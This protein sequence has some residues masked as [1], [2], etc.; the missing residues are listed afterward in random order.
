MPESISPVNRYAFEKEF[1]DFISEVRGFNSRFA[2]QLNHKD[3]SHVSRMHSP[4]VEEVESWLYKAAVKIDAAAR[5]DLSVARKAL[6]MLTA[7]VRR[8]EPEKT[9]VGGTNA[10]ESA[11]HNFR[12]VLAARE[13]GLVS[14]RQVEEAGE[15]LAEATGGCCGK[16]GRIP[17][18]HK[19]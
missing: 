11:Y 7:V 13:D 19:S 1:H 5:A 4:F 18:M 8:H 10:L 15:R 3:D 9:T 17:E 2:E 16:S 12:A 14:Q 6:A